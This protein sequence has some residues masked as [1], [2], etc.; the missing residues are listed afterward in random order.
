MEIIKKGSKGDIVKQIQKIVGVTADGD[1]GSKTEEAVKKY[2]KAHGLVD[3]GLV[4]EK[5]LAIMGIKVDN[6]ND[7]I[8]IIKKPLSVHV[9]RKSNR[10]IK[11]ICI[12][13][14]AGG[15][16]SKGSAASCYNVFTKR[17]ASADFAVDDV[18]IVQFNPDIKNYYCWSVGDGGGHPKIKNSNSISIE[19]CSNLKKGY[20]GHYPNHDGWYYTEKS[21]DNA[22]KLTKYLMKKYNIPSENVVRHYDVTRKC[23][24]GIVGWNDAQILN[25]NNGKSIGVKN[26]SN[27]WIE[28][29]NRL[30]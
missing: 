12:H 28:F 9:S 17:E 18:D 16:S 22:V 10:D 1:F 13:Y 21:L 27:K 15:S 29:K 7:G 3:D 4:G 24:P 26:N 5:T 11:Y 30:K 20:S 23:C 8:N 19:I 14:T 25:P 6:D 2:Q